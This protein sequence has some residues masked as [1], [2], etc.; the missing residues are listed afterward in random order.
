LLFLVISSCSPPEAPSGSTFAD[1]DGGFG[2]LPD[3]LLGAERMAPDAYAFVS[4]GGLRTALNP[5]QRFEITTGDAISLS[6]S[7]DA[8]PWRCSIALVAAGRGEHLRP[9]GAAVGPRRSQDNLLRI[10]R[11][12]GI[13][14]WYVN[15]SSGLE[16]GFVVR[17]RPAGADESLSFEMSIAGDLTPVLAD[18]GFSV[19]L[20]RDGD[21]VLTYGGLAAY[22]DAGQ[23]LPSWMEVRGGAI[24]LRVDDRDASYPLVIDPTLSTE[25][26]SFAADDIELGDAFGFAVAADG[27]TVIIGSENEGERASNAGAAYIFALDATGRW[28]QQAKLL[29]TDSPTD[30]RQ[31]L[32]YAR[33]SF[34]NAVDISGS[35]AVVGRVNADNDNDSSGVAYVFFDTGSGWIQ[36]AQLLPDRDRPSAGRRSAR[37]AQSAAIDGLIAAF[38]SP[39]HQ[40][41][42]AAGLPVTG[43][44]AGSVYPWHGTMLPSGSA[45]WTQAP[46]LL[47]TLDGAETTTGSDHFG[48]SVAISGTTLVVGA[49]D[50]NDPTF[51]SD[52]GAVYVYT[53]DAGWTLQAKLRASDASMSSFF[54]HSVAIEGDTLL[55]G[56]PAGRDG[57]AYVF[58]RSGDTWTERQR[59][60][61]C[62]S[63]LRFGQ[64]VDLRG[65]R[66]IVGTP[67]DGSAY[68]FARVG[69][70][71]TLIEKLEP[72]VTS[73]GVADVGRVALVSDETALIGAPRADTESGTVHHY[74]LAQP[75]GGSCTVDADCA[76]NGCFATGPGNCVDGVCCTTASCGECNACNTPGSLG[77]CAADSRLDGSACGDPSDTECTRPDT[78]GSGA[79]L[80]NHE[81]AMSACGDTGVA[82]LVDDLCDGAGQCTDGGFVAATTACGD[83]T[84]NDCTAP[85]ACDGAGTCAANNAA[86]GALCGELGVDCVLDDTCDG[87]GACVDNG[88]AAAGAACGDPTDGICSGPDVCDAAGACLPNDRPSGTEC[89]DPG[90][91][92]MQTC[93]GVGACADAGLAPEGTAC[94]DGTDSECTGPDTCDAAGTCN[95][96]DLAEG[97]PCG[98]LGQACFEDDSCDGMGMCVDRGFSPAGTMC[99][100]PSEMSCNHADMCDGAGAC[101]MAW[102]PDGTVCPMGRCMTGECVIR[103]GGCGCFVG[104]EA[105][106]R[107]PFEAAIAA[108]LFGLFLTRRRLRR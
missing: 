107:P 19:R 99:G 15:V 39:S 36:E 4:S 67:D 9:V 94:G 29:P 52:A 53:F 25:R 90:T 74:D 73:V 7:A 33:D 76:G 97:T 64:S 30:P 106:G 47:P 16:H 49:P 66:V 24:V 91:C 88:L 50:D 14:E 55:V 71:W 34:G 72:S 58:T 57:A 85:D 98:D 17:R 27:A 40:H 42:D 70:T 92:R 103:Q 31:D 18:D 78:C 22:D 89:G 77:S 59:L 65:D 37:Y 13:S 62:D 41:R 3:F 84:A 87:S 95:A 12:G 1:P 26:G 61:P 6:G 105:N 96:R 28:I 63:V 32:D 86:S 51:G 81:P 100:D 23:P 2:G 83:P 46:E 101:D 69:G 108:F 10:E 79:C 60:Q 20:E 104:P 38:G 93:D 54:G 45:I 56:A 48:D 80:S 11:P 8:E 44:S 68:V 35:R 82:C 102:E 43:G 21:T 5:A 75:I